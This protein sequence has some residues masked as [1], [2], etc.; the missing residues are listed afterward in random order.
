MFRDKIFGKRMI[1]LRKSILHQIRKD[2]EHDIVDK[3]LIK[4]AI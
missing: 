3:D 2:R 1:E 4:E